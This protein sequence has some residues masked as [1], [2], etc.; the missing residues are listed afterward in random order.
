MV[1][2]RMDPHPVFNFLVE[3][4]GVVAG[5]FSEV[6]GLQI[7][8]EIKEYREGGLNWYKHRL[9]GPTHYPSNLILKRGMTESD[10]LI[11]WY[12]A[13]T[14]GFVQ[15]LNGS[16]VLLNAAGDEK[17]RWNFFQAYPCKWIGPQLRAGTAQVA[18]ET[19]EIVHNGI[20]SI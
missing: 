14:L 15:R 3:I 11:K 4:Q 8:T 2:Q 7:E 12:Q 13:V 20:Y 17:Q 18:I 6:T 5:G 9:A 16:V 19:L 10:L 1:K